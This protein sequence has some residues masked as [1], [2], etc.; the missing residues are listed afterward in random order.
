M[1]IKIFPW[2]LIG[3]KHGIKKVVKFLIRT[4]GLTLIKNILNVKVFYNMV[5][6][7]SKMMY[8]DFF[9]VL[10]RNF[11]FLNF[12]NFFVLSLAP[13]RIQGKTSINILIPQ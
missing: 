9:K 8:I 10:I 1:C 6:F 3:T 7:Y 12:Y 13:S 5:K 11:T 4:V 2:I